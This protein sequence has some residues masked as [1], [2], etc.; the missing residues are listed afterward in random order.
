V[1]AEHTATSWLRELV[2]QGARARWPD[3]VPEKARA[4]IDHELA[5]S[6][7]LKYESYFLTVHDIV[8]WA[9]AQGILCQGRGSAAK[10]TVCFA[11]RMT[12]LD[13][14]RSRLLFER[15]LSHERN[16]PPDIDVD[17]APERR[18]EVIQYI[19]HP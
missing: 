19:F 11:L 6:A 17:F 5:L 18:E 10:S 4:L 15:F 16:E 13:P 2:D 7:E 1:P 9:R 12:A 3:G 8:R 14:S